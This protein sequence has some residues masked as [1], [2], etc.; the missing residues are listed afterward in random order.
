MV[1]FDFSSNEFGWCS[2]PGDE[3]ESDVSSGYNAR[4]GVRNECERSA[5]CTASLFLETYTT[6]FESNDV[7]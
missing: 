3:F 2:Q 5:T 1:I 7:T 4:G 6:A